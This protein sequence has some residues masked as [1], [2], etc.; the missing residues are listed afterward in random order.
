[1]FSRFPFLFCFVLLLAGGRALSFGIDFGGGDSSPSV[2]IRGE[3]S[4]ELQAYTGEFRPSAISGARLGDVF[5]GKLNFLASGSYA[6]GTLNFGLAPVFDGSASPLSI[7]EAYARL[8]FGGIQLEGGLRK[9]TWGKADSFGP[10]DVVNPLDYSDLSAMADPAASKI[11]RPLLRLSWNAGDFSKLEAV[12]L[13]S[14]QG[15]RFAEAGRW[16]PAQVSSFREALGILLPIYLTASSSLPPG[17][18]THP[19]FPSSLDNIKGFY[20][21]PRLIESLYP[22]TAALKYA[23]AG[24]RFTTS[25]GP[26]DLGFQ[27]FYGNLFRPALT[28]GGA[29]DFYRNPYDFVHIAYNRYHQIGLDYAQVLGDFNLRAEAAANITEDIRGDDGGVYNPFLGWSLGFDRDLFWG[30]NLNLQG[31][32][33]FRLL[34]DRV[35]GNPLTDAEAGKD[36]TSTRIIILLS[37]KFFQDELELKALGLWGIEDRDFYILP[38]LVWTKDDVSVELSGGIF[39]GRRTGELGQ[40]RDNHFVKFLFTYSV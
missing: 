23:Q 1:M 4:A 37:K 18:V 8:F 33:T 31:A 38:A 13:P 12:F 5:S 28:V 30:I 15:H 2:K 17:T 19:D 22:D 21:N 11:A 24:L 6:S 35:G 29:M 10:L 40:Y 27:Y 9:L 7:D 26:A 14:F 36:L 34:H 32:G 25:L 3:V 20:A 39:G 16:A